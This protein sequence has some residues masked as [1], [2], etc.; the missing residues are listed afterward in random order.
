VV[1]IVRDSQLYMGWTGDSQVILVK[2]GVPVFV[3]E[4]HKPS[5]K[6]STNYGTVT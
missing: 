3:S 6:A 5:K 4:P 1:A 2:R